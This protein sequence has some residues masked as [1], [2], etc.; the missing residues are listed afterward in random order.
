MGKGA[1]V[2]ELTPEQ[3]KQVPLVEL[4]RAVPEKA[5]L[6]FPLP[7]TSQFEGS[8]NHPVG[9]LC[10]E[11]ADKIDALTAELDAANLE[12]V[13]WRTIG[14]QAEAQLQAAREQKPV[15]YAF[16]DTLEQFQKGIW[17]EVTIFKTGDITEGRK[18]M[19]PL[20]AAPVP[21]QPAWTGVDSG[22]EMPAAQQVTRE[23]CNYLA[24]QGTVC[25]K[26]GEVHK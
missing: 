11:A 2:S 26:C 24:M 19:T 25:N 15:G 1:I 20:Y 17:R 16:T 4:L 13:K 12:V 7:G 6:L 10:H 8:R 9:R 14:A 3:G 21:A 18:L 5:C 23:G 22:Y